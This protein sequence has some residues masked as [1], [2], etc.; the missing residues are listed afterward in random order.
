VVSFR[1]KTQLRRALFDRAFYL[2]EYP[3][4]AAAGVDPWRHYLRHGAREGRKPNPWFDPAYYLKTSPDVAA[5]GE[6]P[7]LHFLGLRGAEC[8]NPH[9]L[10]DCASYLRAHPDAA[11]MNL[12]EHRILK[13]TAASASQGALFGCDS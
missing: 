12:L 8:A 7:F 2:R 11:N 10:F 4:V 13:S 5:S 3:D 6:D 9:P 1:R